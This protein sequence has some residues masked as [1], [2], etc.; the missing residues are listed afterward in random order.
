MK[1]LPSGGVFICRDWDQ[2]SGFGGQGWEA[3]QSLGARPQP[4]FEESTLAGA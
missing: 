4:D 3:F 2:G 1:A